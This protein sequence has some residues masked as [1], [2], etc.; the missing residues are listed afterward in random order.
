MGL[1]P[2]GSAGGGSVLE[3]ET[4]GGSGACANMKQDKSGQLESFRLMCRLC[5]L[6]PTRPHGVVLVCLVCH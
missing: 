6:I 3:Q 2:S 4:N 1:G 5:P